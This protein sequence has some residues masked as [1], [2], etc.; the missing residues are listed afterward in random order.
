M[1]LGNTELNLGLD[2]APPQGTYFIAA[3]CNKPKTA[4]FHSKKHQIKCK[5]S[6]KK[7]IDPNQ[8]ALGTPSI[9]QNA[10]HLVAVNGCTLVAGVKLNHS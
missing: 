10:P 3:G 8:V 5:P 9:S 4:F 7:Q 1:Y 6:V 2:L